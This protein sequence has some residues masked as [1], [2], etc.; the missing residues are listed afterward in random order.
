[1][2]PPKTKEIESSINSSK[3]NPMDNK[4]E[5]SGNI[6]ED[7]KNPDINGNSSLNL[8]NNQKNEIKLLKSEIELLKNQREKDQSKME[9]LKSFFN[10]EINKLQREIKSLSD[11]LSSMKNKK[12]KYIQKNDNNINNID[13]DDKMDLQESD[14]NIEEDDHKYQLE[15]LS[16]KLNTEIIQGADRAN[17]N[18]IVRNSSKEKFPLNSGLICDSKNSLLLCE[19]IDLSG[20]EPNKQKKINIQFKNLKNISKGEYKSICKLMVENKIYHSS[21]IQLIIK[22]IASP[23]NQNNQINSLSNARNYQNNPFAINMNNGTNLISK[24]RNQFSLLDTEMFSD[25]VIDNALRLNNNDFNK[26]F[27]SLFN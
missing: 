8:D 16:R 4:N 1:M 18:I 13:N 14:D 19:S 15:C 26:A 12:N 23:N 5:N 27:E 21:S 6:N 2:E 9:E 22:V 24:F 3:Q 20:L 7:N 10:S 11:E 25:Q 17:L